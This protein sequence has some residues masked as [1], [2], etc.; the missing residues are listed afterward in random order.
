MP[1]VRWKILYIILLSH[2][3]YPEISAEGARLQEPTGMISDGWRPIFG[4]RRPAVGVATPPNSPPSKAIDVEIVKSESTVAT[5]TTTPRP[6]EGMKPVKISTMK[7]QTLPPNAVTIGRPSEF[8]FRKLPLKPIG[9]LVKRKPL[10]QIAAHST[11]SEVYL[12]P[13]TLVSFPMV[14]QSPNTIRTREAQGLGLFGSPGHFTVNQPN[15]HVEIN[16]YPAH[17]DNPFEQY[18]SPGVA[19]IVPKLKQPP[20]EYS[21]NLVPPPPGRRPADKERLKLA[22][23]KIPEKFKED[24]FGAKRPPVGENVVGFAPKPPAAV[25]VQVTKEN[26]KAFH[27]LF[28]PDYFDYEYRQ[29]PKLQTYEVTEGKWFDNPNPFTFNYLKPK[30]QQVQQIQQVQ[31]VQQVQQAI[32]PQIT[33]EPIVELNIPPFLPTPIKPDPAYPTSPTQSEASTVFNQISQKMNKYKTAALANN[34][35]FF[36]IKEVSTHYPILGRPE[37]VYETQTVSPVKDNE[38]VEE[39]TTARPEEVTTKKRRRRPQPRRPTSTSTTSTTT[40]A[41]TTTTEDPQTTEAY[42]FQKIQEELGFETDKPPKRH[43]QRPNRYRYPNVSDAQENP[44]R[45]GTTTQATEEEDKSR[46]RHRYRQRGKDPTEARIKDQYRKRIRTTT[47]PTNHKYQEDSDFESKYYQTVE[48][49]TKPQRL[50]EY[51]DNTSEDYETTPLND[52]RTRFYATKSA[53]ETTTLNNINEI[54]STTTLSPKQEEPEETTLVTTAAP[55]PT[56]TKPTK[57]RTRPTLFKTRP[58]FSVKDY[59]QRL[60]HISSST[61]SS[62][63]PDSTKT[64]PETSRFRFPSRLR[65]RPAQTSTTAAPR[66]EETTTELVVRRRFKPKDP[67]HTATTTE[68]NVIAE[69]NVKAVNTRLRPFDRQRSTTESSSSKPKVSIKSG[70]YSNRRRPAFNT[71]SKLNDRAES[72]ASKSSDDVDDD[73]SLEETTAVYQ[74]SRITT[75]PPGVTTEAPGL[76][77]LDASMSDDDYSQRISDLTSSFKLEY[78]TPGLFKSVAPISRRVPSYFTISTEDPILPIEA[79]FPKLKDKGGD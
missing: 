27:N 14:K 73:E 76:T 25:D 36:D 34:P 39:V 78:D 18:K 77:T 45:Y 41:T 56:T 42:R 2:Q 60:T 23:S 57:T 63:T 62:T 69:T 74:S 47:I 66:Q 16:R 61:P 11:R 28:K 30:Q 72:I 3:I 31:Q 32:G 70:L 4:N 49:T 26:L 48:T 12:H 10:R 68:A 40:I 6:D 7:Y 24:Q 19:Y 21:R 9:H 53:E 55:K 8:G 38:I 33:N 50:M 46:G 51:D 65:T 13:G 52:A 37:F 44:A 1:P 54:D 64:T 22:S 35:L 59:R 17:S 58:R 43:R 67:R 5:S 71:K 20:D 79:F 29:A 15:A 75:E